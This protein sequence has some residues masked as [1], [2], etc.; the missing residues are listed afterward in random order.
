M[1]ARGALAAEPGVRYS[2]F[3]GENLQGWQVTGCEAGV[4]DGAL[5]LQKGDGFVRT[6]FRYRDFTLELD[7]K[8]RRSEK[9]DSGIY[10]RSEWPAEG[11]SWPTKHQIN[12]KQGDEANLIGFPKA[13]S[14]GLVKAGDW[15]R[16]KLTVVGDK[17]TME[18]NGKPAW[19]TA[20]LEPR[21]GFIGFQCEEHREAGNLN[22]KTSRSPNSIS[23]RCLMAPI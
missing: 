2:L 10:I 9:Y 7:W 21:E 5:V 8:P 20:G 17:A 1:V 18:L 6:D 19:E 16:L 13:R 14:Q 4:E 3:N 22:S 12:L 23:R 15:N 11:K